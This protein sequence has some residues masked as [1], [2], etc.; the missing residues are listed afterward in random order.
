M[1]LDC[2]RHASSQGLLLLPW[3]RS[4]GTASL[5]TTWFRICR[6]LRTTR[7]PISRIPGVT[8]SET[9][10]SGLATTYPEPQLYTTGTALRIRVSPWPYRRPAAPLLRGRL[11]A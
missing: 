3:Q 7:T 2:F 1:E 6:T 8:D 5:Y 11:P 4:P 9:A 10:P